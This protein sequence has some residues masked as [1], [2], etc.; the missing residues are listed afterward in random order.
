MQF[1]WL[2][3]SGIKVCPLAYLHAFISNNQGLEF[4]EFRFKNLNVDFT[5]EI[6]QI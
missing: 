4:L 2:L 3:S 6:G 5:C 1:T